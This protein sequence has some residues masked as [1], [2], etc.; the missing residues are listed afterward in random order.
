M[1]KIAWITDSTAYITE[2][3]KNNQDV[4][5]LPLS[6]IFGAEAYED[7]VDLTTEEL[8]EKINNEKEIPKTSQPS[9][10]KTAEIINSLKG[11]YDAAIAIHISGKLSGTLEA[12]RSA[13]EIADFPVEVID[14][15]SM[16]YAITSLLLSGIRQA[17]TESDHTKIADN[18]R[19]EAEKHENLILL[20]SLEQFYKGGRMSGTQFLLG[21][22]LKIKPIIRINPSG[23]F[24]LSEKVRSE[25]KATKRILELF[26]DS[27]SK[28]K[29][30]EIQIMHGNVPAR[31]QEIKNELS[32]KYP[33]LQ[34]VVG[35]ISSTIAVHAGEGTV[36]LMWQ[37]NPK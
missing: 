5:V 8:Y 22:L 10:G 32:S 36:G 37:N 2:S 12:T 7:G 16:S 15:K 30:N 24:M 1:K 34:F 28:Y 18:L 14:S 20:G 27:Y 19:A 3:L 21:N 17:E 9:V 35:E 26:D 29:V 6:I 23:E 4:F 13:A 33:S 31:A 11:D 25:K